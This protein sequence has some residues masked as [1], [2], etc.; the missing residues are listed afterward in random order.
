[1]IALQTTIAMIRAGEQIG[2]ILMI[3]Q[4][5]R[6]PAC[7][8]RDNG[9]GTTATRTHILKSNKLRIQTRDIVSQQAAGGAE[10]A[11]LESLAGAGRA[12]AT[13]QMI[14]T[15]SDHC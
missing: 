2:V 10:P 1:M 12:D 11:C 13:M 9:L 5:R 14:M 8:K 3:V 7:S 15:H 6:V 4:V